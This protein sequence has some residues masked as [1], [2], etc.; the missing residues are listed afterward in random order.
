AR[1]I[2]DGPG[3][4]L[5][6]LGEDGHLPELALHEAQA[7]ERLEPGTKQTN[8][9]L[10]IAAVGLSFG[11]TI[12][13]LFMDV[14]SFAGRDEEKAKAR[15]EIADY[16]GEGDDDLKPYQLRLREARLARSRR[17][18]EGERKQLRLVLDMLRS[19]VNG[20]AGLTGRIGYRE[21]DIDK[22][23]DKRLEE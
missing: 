3:D 5:V 23:S 14:G 19:E 7:G 13:M 4:P 8:P 9:V 21:S 16:Y 10:L 1:F 2:T 12:L 15:V 6:K 11:L 17:D 22:K 18:V 20:Y